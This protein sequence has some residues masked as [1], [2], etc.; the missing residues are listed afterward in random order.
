M[1]GI[2]N[3]VVNRVVRIFTRKAVRRAMRTT[4]SSSGKR[5]R[6]GPKKG[7]AEGKQGAR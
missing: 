2:G 4:K 3:V 1:G 6:T 7:S 5:K